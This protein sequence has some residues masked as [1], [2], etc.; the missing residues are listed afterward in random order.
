MMSSLYALFHEPISRTHSIV[1]GGAFDLGVLLPSQKS[2]FTTGTT[3][4]NYPY[5]RRGNAGKVIADCMPRKRNQEFIPFLKKIDAQT[6]TGLNLH[7]I[8]DN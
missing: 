8:V 6:P 3:G 5:G 1:I 4:P 7:Q 2:R